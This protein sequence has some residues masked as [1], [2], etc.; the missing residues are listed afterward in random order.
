[1]QSCSKPCR[2]MP[3]VWTR[4]A[5]LC[6]VIPYTLASCLLHL[7]SLSDLLSWGQPPHQQ[8][9]SHKSIVIPHCTAAFLY[10]VP[11]QRPSRGHPRPAVAYLISGRPQT[12][13]M[14]HG[15]NTPARFATALEWAAGPQQLCRVTWGG[16]ASQERNI[17]VGQETEQFTAVLIKY[18]ETCS[19][20]TEALIHHRVLIVCSAV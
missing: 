12:T 1:M 6:F 19:A 20:E 5:Q 4:F 2:T 8:P 16:D 14:R 3:W 9:S 13:G 7:L 10:T 18:R 17:T 11:R 15:S